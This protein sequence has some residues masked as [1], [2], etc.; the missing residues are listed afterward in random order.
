MNFSIRA[1]TGTVASFAGLCSAVTLSS[2][3]VLSGCSKE[4]AA[5]EPQSPAGAAAGASSSNPS[6]AAAAPAGNTQTAAA[7]GASTSSGTPAEPSAGGASPGGG[8]GADT[9]AGGAAGTSSTAS[10]SQASTASGTSA[11]PVNASGP[12]EKG[13][14]DKAGKGDK[15]ASGAAKGGAHADG[16]SGA[17]ASAPA[18]CGE[19]GQPACPLQGWMKSTM[20]PAVSGGDT[21]AVAKALEYVAAHAPPGMPNWAS[22]ARD[23]AAKA[24][25]G[26]LAGA[27]ASCKSCHDQYKSRYKAEMR[28]RSF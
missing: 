18:A 3:L 22:I 15:R 17:A 11:T 13:S 16:A 20:G 9:S 10:A 27:K 25:A 7:G 4:G 24:K 8:T 6:V 19:K 26:D 5:A 12:G 28:A 1:K 23:G 2:L 14:K 21:A